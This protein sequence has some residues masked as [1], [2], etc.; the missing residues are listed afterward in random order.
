MLLQRFHKGRLVEHPYLNPATGE[1]ATMRGRVRLCPYYF[2]DGGKAHLRG[3]LATVCPA[4]KKLLHGM[5]DAVIVP[6]RVSEDGL[7]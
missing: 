6:A 5:R 1:M 7:A 2:L 4:D 3:V